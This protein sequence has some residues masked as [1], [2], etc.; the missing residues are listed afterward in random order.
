MYVFTATLTIFG[1]GVLL[2]IMMLSEIVAVH[3]D[4]KLAQS[5]PL[6]HQGMIESHLQ[7]KVCLQ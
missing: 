3:F 5:T 6:K 7:A 2:E 4:V 1:I